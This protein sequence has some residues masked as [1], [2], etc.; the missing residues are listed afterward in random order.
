MRKI[1]PGEIGCTLSHQKCYRKIIDEQLPCALILEDDL[2]PGADFDSL[3]SLLEPLLST[4]EPRVILLSGDFWWLTSR[5]LD[6]T[7][8][9]ARL[10]DGYMTHAYLI[11]RAGACRI[12]DDRPG[13]IADD[14]RY[15][16]RKGL[17]VYGLL[18]HA[19]DQDRSGAFVSSIN[20]SRPQRLETRWLRF[21]SR[22][23]REPFKNLRKQLLRKAGRYEAVE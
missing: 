18:P 20:R 21:R 3:I 10:F 4:P 2:L 6:D 16:I 13:Y 7:H 8:R 15:L 1:R 23:W 14:W 22:I 17:H 11:N 12:F 5:P 9:L 19:V